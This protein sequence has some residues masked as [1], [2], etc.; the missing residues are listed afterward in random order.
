MI[1]VTEGGRIT[2]LTAL[3]AYVGWCQEVNIKFV[4]L[5]GEHSIL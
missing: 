5:V 4:V 2:D 3:L 1:C